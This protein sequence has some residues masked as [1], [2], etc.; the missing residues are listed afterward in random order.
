MRNKS[1]EVID[2]LIFLNHSKLSLNQMK[3]E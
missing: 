3:Q 1:S 2:L